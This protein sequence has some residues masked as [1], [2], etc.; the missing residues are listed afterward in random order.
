VL[1]RDLETVDGDALRR[2]EELLERRL[3]GEPVAYLVGER[4]FYGRPFTV[5]RRVLIP[6]PETEHLVE[7]ALAL[8]LPEAPRV[9]DVGAGSG[10]IAVTLALELPAARVVASDV[11]LGAL[12]VL[13]A[14]VERHGVGGRVDAIACD[15]ARALRLDRFDLVVSNPPYIDPAERSRLSPEVVDFEPAEAL[16]APDSGRAFL[17]R[18]LDAALESRPGT[19]LL[20]EIGYDQSDWLATAVSQR[21]GLALRDVVR[22]YGGI[23]RT[24]VLERL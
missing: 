6:R 11:S 17:E 21:P 24:A 9:L 3:A 5:D 13:R 2:F 12:R 7:A 19:P 14:N 1:A 18:L 20:V 4:E 15:L 16:F 8:E 22:D 10:C 23:L